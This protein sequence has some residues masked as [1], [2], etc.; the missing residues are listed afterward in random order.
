MGTSVI[1]EKKQ[2][3]VVSR[4]LEGITNNDPTIKCIAP[5]LKNDKW[6]RARFAAKITGI[7]ASE[8]FVK[9]RF[10]PSKYVQRTPIEDLSFTFHD[11]DGDDFC[12]EL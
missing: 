2:L 9:L 5:W 10:I 8:G 12:E 7:V 11:H 6:Y 4:L 3:L 1:V